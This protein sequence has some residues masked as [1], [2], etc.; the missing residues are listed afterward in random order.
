MATKQQQGWNDGLDSREHLLSDGDYNGWFW[1]G[2]TKSAVSFLKTP[3]IM[4]KPESANRQATIH[5]PD[6]QAHAACRGASPE[7]FTD[8]SPAE[9]LDPKAEWR[10]FCKTCPVIEQCDEFAAGFNPRM[11][12]VYGGKLMTEA[13]L[14]PDVPHRTA[15]RRGRP[16]KDKLTGFPR[17][18]YGKHER[19][20]LLSNQ[21]ITPVGG[22]CLQCLDDRKAR[23]RAKKEAA[24]DPNTH[25]S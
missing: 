19:H 5:A 18:C 1:G 11:T 15:G 6:W 10:G 13:G 17:L 12:G 9:F 8:L 16:P 20:T 4:P 21:D 23:N 22:Y 14:Y 2:M 25:V 7:I 3:P 24:D